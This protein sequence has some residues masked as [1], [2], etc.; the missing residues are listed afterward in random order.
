MCPPDLP[1]NKK[2]FNLARLDIM[3]T[4]DGE[5]SI[6]FADL[7]AV[8][9]LTDGNLASH[10]RVLENLNFVSSF[11]CFVNRKPQTTYTLTSLGKENLEG[12]KKWFSEA[13][14]EGS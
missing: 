4:L 8:C 2:I 5:P 3:M 12:L 11:K 6:P 7:Q 13:I 1:F 9:E 10:L 14:L